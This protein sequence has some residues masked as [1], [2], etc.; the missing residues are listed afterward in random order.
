VGLVIFVSVRVGATATL[1][2]AHELAS[3]IEDD[4]RRDADHIAD[5]VVHTEP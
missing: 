3:R 1:R 2:E 5:V 4:I